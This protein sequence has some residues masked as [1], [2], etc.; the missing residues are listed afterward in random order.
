MKR[1]LALAAAAVGVTAAVSVGGMQA[2]SAATAHPGTCSGGPVAS[3]TY[4]TLTITGDCFVPDNARIV[5]QKNLVVQPGATFDAQSHGKV[6]VMGDVVAQAGS[7]FALGCTPAHPCETDGDTTEVPS[8]D[9]VNGSVYLN[10]VFDAA[11]NG[12]TIRGNLVANGGGPGYSLDPWIPYSMKDNVIKG[13]VTVN[14]IQTS[15][16]GLIRNK[17]GGSVVLNGIRGADPDS[18][19]VVA[20]NI[21]GNLVCSGMSPAPQLGDAVGGAPP[22]YGPNTVHGVATGQCASIPSGSG[23]GA[24]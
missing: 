20:N 5:V 24:L 15:W 17:I 4:T 2:A 9:I 18:N 12:D 1:A 13:N 21:G 7:S 16:W 10:N 22:G 11:I 6:K 8:Q 3:G 23:G 19:E 14:G